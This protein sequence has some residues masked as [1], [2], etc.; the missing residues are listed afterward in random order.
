MITKKMLR[1]EYAFPAQHDMK[2]AMIVFLS[3][4]QMIRYNG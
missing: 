3:Q 2:K 1:E 4:D